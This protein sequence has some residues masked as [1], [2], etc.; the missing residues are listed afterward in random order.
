MGHHTNNAKATRASLAGDPHRP[1]YH[2]LPPANW[3][4]D[5]NGPIQWRGTYHL[6]YQHNPDAPHWGTMHWGHTASRDLVHWD[7]LPI[8]LTPTP[9]SPDEAGCFSGCAVDDGGTPTLIYTGVR[10]QRPFTQQQC[11]AVSHD[12]LLTWEKDPANPIIAAPP[13]GVA[14]TDFRD[15]CVWREEDGWYMV[16]GASLGGQAGAVLLYRSPDLRH[17]E[18]LGV[19]YTRSRQEHEPLPTGWMW[20]CPQFFPLGDRHVLIVS[21]M[22]EGR[23]NHVA[24]FVGRYEGHR[25]TPERVERLDLGPD[26]YAPITFQD[27]RGRRLMWGWSWEGRSPEAQ[28]AAGWAGVMALPRVLTLR[29]DGALGIEPAPE[30]AMLRRAQ[31]A[32]PLCSEGFSPSHSA[33]ASASPGPGQAAQAT[34]TWVDLQG[35]CLEILA[36]F[37]PDVAATRFGLRVRCSPGAEEETLI[38]YDRPSSRLV[39]D[40][41]RAS[42]DPAAH[43][44]RHGG[45]LRLS[46]GEPLRLHV[47]LDRS[48]VEVYA[49][50]RVSLTARIYPTRPDS[51]GLGPLAWGGSARLRSLRVWELASIW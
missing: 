34:T 17:W 12:G 42:L 47:F 14:A 22:L 5:P 11:L 18:Y 28:R 2:F 24:C 21:A 31:K 39:L 50:G 45:P 35:D 10:G 8:A 7:D 40:R 36:E 30:I 41:E 9:G 38:Y 48:I 19:P 37:E 6:F 43:R 29:P 44:G 25:F 16:L 46:A 20:E 27:E 26:Y 32:W 3:M 4:N 51:L 49:N 15:P 1:R 23:P 13:P 33:G